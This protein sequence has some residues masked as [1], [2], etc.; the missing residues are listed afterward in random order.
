MKLVHEV[1]LTK[2]MGAWRVEADIE[3]TC[4]F[5]GVVYERWADRVECVA[6][7]FREGMDMTSWQRDRG[8]EVGVVEGWDRDPGM[9]SGDL[10]NIEP[11]F[12]IC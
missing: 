12:S 6:R 7:H 8:A 11:G 3:S 2:D 10:M 4:G 5:C 9:R 1:G